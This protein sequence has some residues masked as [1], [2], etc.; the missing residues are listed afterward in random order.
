MKAFIDKEILKSKTASF[1]I[2]S[3]I[4]ATIWLQLTVVYIYVCQ[5][6]FI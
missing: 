4:T 2:Q 1:P 3:F 5:T 6:L